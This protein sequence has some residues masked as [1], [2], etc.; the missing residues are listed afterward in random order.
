M[1]SEART[2]QEGTTAV[3]AIEENEEVVFVFEVAPARDIR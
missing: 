3:E 1:E 2:E